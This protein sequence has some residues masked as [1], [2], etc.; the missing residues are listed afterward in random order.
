M[1]IGVAGD[2]ANCANRS[3]P[4][5]DLRVQILHPLP[6]AAK[7]MRMSSR[8]PPQRRRPVVGDSGVFAPSWLNA[9]SASVLTMKMRVE[10]PRAA[11]T[12]LSTRVKLNGWSVGF[13]SRRL[14]VRAPSRA[15]VLCKK[16]RVSSTVERLSYKQATRVRLLH[17]APDR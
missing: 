1:A 16:G 8:L 4:E 6:M 10:V 15:L 14:W 17:P 11:P 12:L 3:P 7:L 13:R 5:R 9:E 2:W